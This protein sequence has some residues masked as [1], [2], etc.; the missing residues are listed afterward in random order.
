MTANIK[1]FAWDGNSR[2]PGHSKLFWRRRFKI[3][4]F[5]DLYNYDLIQH[6]YGLRGINQKIPFESRLFLV[7]STLK[8]A[9]P[10]D[11]V[12]GA[13]LRDRYQRSEVHL[14][15][16]FGLRGKLTKDVVESKVGELPNLRFLG[17]PGI[18]ASQVYGRNRDKLSKC[19]DVTFL[20]HFEDWNKWSYLLSASNQA[21]LLSP[22]NIPEKVFKEIQAS[23]L[24]VTSSL[25]GLI[26][27][28]SARVPCIF[29]EPSRQPLF[30]YRDYF[31]TLPVELPEPFRIEFVLRNL[32]HIE[33][34]LP[35][36]DPE[37]MSRAM[38]TL[39]D[40]SAA[41]LEKNANS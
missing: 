26:F 10:N 37:A 8:F 32:G 25:H 40:L 31:S 16:V 22:D 34:Q 18:L 39:Q 11:I 29:V 28:H 21:K 9:K 35:D 33:G 2:L 14:T 13:G 3:G 12:S 6:L 38:P 19:R 4:N 17:D 7:G 15:K 24:V 1:M 5:G 27:S 23:E 41:R 20:P 36:V 30:K